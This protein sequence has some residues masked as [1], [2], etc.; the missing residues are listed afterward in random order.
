MFYGRLLKDS[1]EEFM[2]RLGAI[3]GEAFTNLDNIERA[4]FMLV[5]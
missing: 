1:R 2:V 5:L 3:L 4:S